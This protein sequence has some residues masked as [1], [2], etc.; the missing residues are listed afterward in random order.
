MPWVDESRYPGE[1]DRLA[2]L[3]LA[4]DPAHMM[5][6]LAARAPVTN[7][8]GFAITGLEVDI[9]RRHGNRCV[10]R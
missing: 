3:P 8:T 1:V 10:I 7:R 4:L 6:V 9:Y 2:T 5:P